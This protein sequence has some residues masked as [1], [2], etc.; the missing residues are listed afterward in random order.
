MSPSL[1]WA[2]GPRQGRIPERP[3]RAGGDPPLPHGPGE[4][5]RRPTPALP[6][7]GQGR[8][9]IT[10][11]LEDTTGIKVAPASDAPA[12]PAT[13]GS[14]TI[15]SAKQSPEYNTRGN[16]YEPSMRKTRPRG[17][18]TSNNPVGMS[19]D[20][21]PRRGPIGK[22][23]ITSNTTQPGPQAWTNNEMQDATGEVLM[24][25]QP[26]TRSTPRR[27]SMSRI[28]QPRGCEVRR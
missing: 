23:R 28:E 12:S 19:Q 5:P 10:T 20:G 21:K 22:P 18:S 7:T 16:T 9:H 1:T 3:G 15:H 13:G 17:W 24:Q 2:A 4:I 11:I 27:T 6:H 8:P 25:A 14:N 26:T